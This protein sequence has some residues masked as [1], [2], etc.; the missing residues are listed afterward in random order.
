VVNGVDYVT[1]DPGAE[2]S[3]FAKFMTPTPPASTTASAPVTAKSSSRRS[4]AP[5]AGL[6]PD[7]KDGKAQA[8]ALAHPGMPVYVPKLIAAGSAYCSGTLGNCPAEIPT[9]GSY[10]REYLIRSP[11]HHAYS[12]YQMTLA[13]NPAL[14]QYY[15]VQGMTWQN[16]PLLASPTMVRVVGGKRLDL[17]VAG[18]KLGVVA[19]HT[20]RGVYWISNTLTNNLD[21]QQM[22]GLAAS[23][24][25]AP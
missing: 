17:Y 25:P 3:A 23:L 2:Q 15:D 7:L 21:K 1:A 18:S 6:T 22:I 10:P 24:V 4:R 19:W 12:A 16:P 14:G 20:R 8:A 9:V 13:L 5:T 11:Q